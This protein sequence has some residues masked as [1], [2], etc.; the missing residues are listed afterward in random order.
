MYLHED[1]IYHPDKLYGG[2]TI[3]HEIK[4]TRDCLGSQ[5]SILDRVA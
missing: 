1:I 3:V 4:Y 5:K 2:C